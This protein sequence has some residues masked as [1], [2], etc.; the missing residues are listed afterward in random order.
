MESRRG[1]AALAALTLLVAGLAVRGGRGVADVG[2]AGGG[3][4]EGDEE[5]K[6]GQLR[7]QDFLHED[8]LRQLKTLLLQDANAALDAFHGIAL[9]LQATMT[10]IPEDATS[11]DDIDPYADIEDAH[12]LAVDSEGTPT[13]TTES[14]VLEYAPLGETEAEALF[15]F[16]AMSDTGLLNGSVPHSDNLTI[17]ALLAAAKAG[18]RNAKLALADRYF[19]GRGVDSSCSK[20]MLYAIDVAEDLIRETEE[21]GEYDIP[22]APIDLRMGWMDGSYVSTADIESALEQMAYEDDV[23]LRGNAN[24]RRYLSY[25]TVVGMR[26]DDDPTEALRAFK[27]LAKEGDE[28]AEFNLGFMY[29]RGIAVSVDYGK[30]FEHWERAAAQ[31]HLGAYYH[32]GLMRLHG[33]GVEKDFQEAKAFFEKCA[34]GEYPDC[35]AAQADML[36]TGEFGEPQNLDKALQLYSDADENGQWRSSYD[37]A[38][39]HWRG[40]GLPPNC[41]AAADHI[42]RFIEGRYHFARQLEAAERS[43]KAGKTWAALVHYVLLSE[44]GSEAGAANAAFML[45]RGWGHSSTARFNFAVDLYL[46]SWKLGNPQSIVAA[47]NLVYFADVFD[48]EEAGEEQLAIA[49]DLYEL[50]AGMGDFE[51]CYCLAWMYQHGEGVEKNLTMAAELYGRAIALSPS[52]GTAAPSAVAL[53]VLHLTMLFPGLEFALGA[54]RTYLRDLVRL[55]PH[56]EAPQIGPTFLTGPPGVLGYLAACLRSLLGDDVKMGPEGAYMMALAGVFA[57]VSWVRWRRYHWRWRRIHGDEARGG[58]PPA[59]RQGGPNGERRNVGQNAGEVGL[60]Q[61]R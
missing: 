8:T 50:G 44:E 51:A 39:M 40:E 48:L 22:L 46:R 42:S 56:V 25:R 60:R 49:A 36:R 13:E 38:V 7:L 1:R 19:T 6:P 35:V 21:K 58:P 24:A 18:S 37:L 28:L 11:D 30:A 14:S 15:L 27:V 61:R 23:E 17:H 41:T 52:E 9:F 3:L 26:L 29:F 45:E 59:G 43:L 57:W 10:E 2:D 47:G 16:A 31:G 5:S 33:Y 55:K 34:K 4:G 53:A 54:L 20:G 32:L 12:G